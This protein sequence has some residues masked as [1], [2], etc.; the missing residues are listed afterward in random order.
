[1]L[2]REAVKEI[3]AAYLEGGIEAGLAKADELHT[4]LS[5]ISEASLSSDAL[6]PDGTLRIDMW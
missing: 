2:S 5:Q 4:L 3:V 1:M 6:R